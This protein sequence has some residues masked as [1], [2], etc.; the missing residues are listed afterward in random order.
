MS[1]PK[2]ERYRREVSDDDKARR[3]AEIETLLEPRQGDMFARLE[4]NEYSFPAFGVTGAEDKYSDSRSYRVRTQLITGVFRG[5]R[6]QSD[7]VGL[8][9]EAYEWWIFL[10]S[11]RAMKK[12]T[13]GLPFSIQIIEAKDKKDGVL[14]WNGNLPV[15]Y[16]DR[17]GLDDESS[18]LRGNRYAPPSLSKKGGLD[19]IAI[20]IGNK[21]VAELFGLDDARTLADPRSLYKTLYETFES[22]R[23]RILKERIRMMPKKFF[24]E[25]IFA[26]YGVEKPAGYN[27][28]LDQMMGEL[29]TVTGQASGEAR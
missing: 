22:L 16:T 5:V 26:L 3:L 2:S 10:D 9:G 13:T 29:E 19:S 11:I 4:F 27:L 28:T 6:Y 14:V 12:R 20:V 8:N 1:D 21:A 18:F 15:A 25:D 17:L 23:E 24:K 7:G